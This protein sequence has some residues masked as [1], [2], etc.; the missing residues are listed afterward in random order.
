MTMYGNVVLDIS[1]HFVERWNEI[2]KRK[3]YYPFSYLLT[4]YSDPF[5]SFSIEMIGE[6]QLFSCDSVVDLQLIWY[7][8]LTLG[9]LYPMTPKLRQMKQ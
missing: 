5:A 6:Q 7:E 9:L 1:Q 4:L 2:K 3:V 8:A